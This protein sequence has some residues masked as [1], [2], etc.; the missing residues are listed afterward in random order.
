M[1]FPLRRHAYL[2][3]AATAAVLASVWFAHLGLLFNLAAAGIAGYWT[4]FVRRRVLDKPNG[5]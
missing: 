2:Y 1:L 5:L 4:S 3:G